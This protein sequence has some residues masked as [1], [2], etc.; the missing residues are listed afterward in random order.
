MSRPPK[1]LMPQKS[2]IDFFGWELR[3]RREAA[4]YRKL[5]AFAR[6]TGKSISHISDVERGKG[7]CARD[8]AERCDEVLKTDGFFGNLWALVDKEWN[9]HAQQNAAAQ[10]EQERAIKVVALDAPAVRSRTTMGIPQRGAVKPYSVTA[11]GE[12]WPREGG[13]GGAPEDRNAGRE[14]YCFRLPGPDG[15]E[16]VIEQLEGAP[17]EVGANQGLA[18]RLVAIDRNTD[19]APML[20]SDQVAFPK[21]KPSKAGTGM[22]EGNRR[23]RAKVI[24]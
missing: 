14:R 9:Q 18:L 10:N 19:E 21:R 5:D 1:Q 22:V 17:L 15:Y 8:F 4:G 7:R 23:W 12:I 13:A 2:V 3:R 20:T 24:S 16:W 11:S 6:R